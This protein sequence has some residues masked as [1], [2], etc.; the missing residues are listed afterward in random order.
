LEQYVIDQPGESQWT[1]PGHLALKLST[2]CFARLEETSG[3]DILRGLWVKLS[4]LLIQAMESSSSDISHDYRASQDLI[5]SR[6]VRLFTLE[7]EV[8]R[9]GSSLRSLAV[10]SMIFRETVAHLIQ[11]SVRILRSRNGE[12]YGAAAVIDEAVAKVPQMTTELKD[13]EAFLEDDIPSLLSSPSGSRLISLLFCCRSRNGFAP[14]FSKSIDVLLSENTE[15]SILPALQK[16]LSSLNSNDIQSH[17]ELETLIM[18]NLNRALE[19]DRQLWTNINIV[20][21]NPAFQ[22]GVADQIFRSVV[23]RLSLDDSVLEPLYGLSQ[24]VSRNPASVRTFTNGPDGSRL[25]SRLLYLTESP[26]D[27][28][29]FL[30]G[31]LGRSIKGLADGD[32]GKKSSVAIIQHNF[33]EIGSESLS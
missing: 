30:A 20:I 19:G 23:D 28:I 22:H 18:R 17:P 21:E 29:S 24:I 10:I 27:E 4:N 13:L 8:L 15:T 5:C 25:I 1:L 9:R 14:G 26:A 6:A 7:S 3:E 32:D 12:S 11:H 31:S 33:T 2:D 16:L